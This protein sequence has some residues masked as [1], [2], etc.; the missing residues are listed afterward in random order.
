MEPIWIRLRVPLFEHKA[1]SIVRGFRAAPG[2]HPSIMVNTGDAYIA[3]P[4]MTVLRIGQYEPISDREAEEIERAAQ[5]AAQEA[6]R[7]KR[8][9]ELPAQFAERLR[10]IE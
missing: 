8:Y 10:R 9:A 2:L 5:V 6:E 7:K 4:R 1:G 3:K